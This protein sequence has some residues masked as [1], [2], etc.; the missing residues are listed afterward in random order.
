VLTDLAVDAEVD[1]GQRDRF[2]S[3]SDVRLENPA[4]DQRTR[5]SLQLDVSGR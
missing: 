2:D 4:T 1:R 3:E 5:D